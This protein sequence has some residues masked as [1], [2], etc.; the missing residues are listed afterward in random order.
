M[1]RKRH[2]LFILEY[3][4]PHLGGVETFFKSLVE[5]LS[6][7]DYQITI[8]TNRFYKTLDKIEQE[9]NITIRRYSFYNRYLFTFLAWIPA[10][11]YARQADLIH[12]TSFNAAVP[13]RLVAKLTRTKSIITFH[14]YWGKLW[15]DLPWISSISRK[16][17]YFFE[18]LIASFNFDY[19]VAVSD[20]TKKALLDA[21]V[22]SDRVIR[23]YNGIN[24]KNFPTYKPKI[25]KQTF[26]FLF[27]GRIS[28]S[29]GVDLLIDAIDILIE[30][31]VEFKI[32]LVIP[33]EA[34]SIYKEVMTRL[35]Q[36]KYTRYIE[37]F[38]DLAF[39]KLTNMIAT[40]DAVVIPSYSEGF[41]FAAV[42]TMAIGTP[43]VSS[44]RGALHEVV[45]GKQIEL[46]AFGS[47]HLAVAM[48]KAI[49]GDWTEKP[50]IKF[51]LEDTVKA[52]IELYD[53]LL[54]NP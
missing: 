36:K 48:K 37:S 5:T 12:T 45:S 14:E 25:E 54:S 4:A 41:C 10:L 23:I 1:S 46:E 19:F 20:S 9:G 51:K 32:Q 3:Y 8:I 33:S 22:P 18:R 26:T 50:L 35:G 7:Q 15:F 38:H 34:T 49:R 47:D 11:K 17:F 31:K 42:E 43:I 6:Q 21:E 2:V 16:L 44:G 24:Y 40:A 13:A 39:G 28:F 27:F 52:Y 53:S 29:K 30:D